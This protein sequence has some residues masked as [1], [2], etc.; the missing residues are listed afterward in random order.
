MARNRTFGPA[1]ARPD[2]KF[3]SPT[4]PEPEKSRPVSITT[5]QYRHRSIN[6]MQSLISEM[7]IA[8]LWWETKFVQIVIIWGLLASLL[9][10]GASFDRWQAALSTLYAPASV[11]RAEQY[12]VDVGWDDFPYSVHRS[13]HGVRSLWNNNSE[14]YLCKLLSFLYVLLP[15]WR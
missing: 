12:V 8:V 10:Y 13:R 11:Y 5:V 15:K 6:S 4:R 9:L 14:I 1:R 7:W 2:P 3:K